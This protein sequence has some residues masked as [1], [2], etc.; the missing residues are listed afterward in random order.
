MR[1]CA[2]L[3]M[4]VSLSGCADEARRD[5]DAEAARHAAAAA[6]IARDTPQSLATASL[7]L[8]FKSDP[9]PLTLLDRAVAKA[10]ADAKLIYLQWRVCAI[11][12][13]ADEPKIIAQLKAVD[14][15]NGVAWL[16][17]L[18]AARESQTQSEV[19]RLLAAIGATRGVTIYW[20][21]LNVMM[22]DALNE[23]ASVQSMAAPGKA[24]AANVLTAVGI[25][26]AVAIPPLQSLAKTCH[27]E[28]FEFTG[29][30]AA[31][32]AMTKRLWTSDAAILQ[33]L[34]NSIQQRWWPE[35]S[36][37]RRQ[38]RAQRRQYDYL[39]E[40]SS[41]PR[42]LHANSDLALRLE[43]MR[44]FPSEADVERAVLFYYHEPLERPLNWKPPYPF[45]D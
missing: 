35:D 32:E 22:V 30:R 41:R 21:P 15:D 1:V 33:G 24:L 10:P 5:D 27:V 40:E 2:L 8:S 4:V 17:Q 37:Q 12:K 23:N 20:N 13:C 42:P 18:D 26:A 9:R 3:L 44:N 43:A 16:P 7:L 25:L 28:Q 14:P 45:H 36:A 38:L 34:S 39:M 29:R 6:L 31:C 11:L 19:T